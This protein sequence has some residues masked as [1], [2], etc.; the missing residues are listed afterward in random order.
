MGRRRESLGNL[1]I[2]DIVDYE[3]QRMRV[4]GFPNDK[5]VILTTL[6]LTVGKPPSVTVGAF[7]K[8]ITVV[9]PATGGRK[10]R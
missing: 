2:G 8:K 6:V 1:H 4:S 3:G 5:L 9:V 10:V 7:D